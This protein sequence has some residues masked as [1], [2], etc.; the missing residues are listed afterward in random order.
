MLDSLEPISAS[1]PY[2]NSETCRDYIKNL[3]KTYTNA[4]ARLEAATS[5]IDIL[6]ARAEVYELEQEI[7]NF[8]SVQAAIKAFSEKQDG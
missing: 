5:S 3:Y 7:Y 6:N 8:C 4:Y 1:R 2:M